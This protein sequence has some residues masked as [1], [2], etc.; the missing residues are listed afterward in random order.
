[1]SFLGGGGQGLGEGGFP[2]RAELRHC[3]CQ[4]PIGVSLGGNL[5]MGPQGSPPP[6]HAFQG[7]RA[8]CQEPPVCSVGGLC[9]SWG[10]D[11]GQRGPDSGQVAY[12]QTEAQRVPALC[13]PTHT[14]SA[15]WPAA[16]LFARPTCR[17]RTSG[18]R[19]PRPDSECRVDSWRLQ[20]PPA[21]P[22]AQPR[23]HPSP[24]L[25][26]TLEIFD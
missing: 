5:G 14:A 13:P 24:L 21:W 20:E 25:I 8:G 1:M 7:V 23:Q 10:A 6:C 18:C 15:P 11:Y 4:G 9:T 17:T 16:A 26:I 2:E 3:L 19:W 12:R 22:P